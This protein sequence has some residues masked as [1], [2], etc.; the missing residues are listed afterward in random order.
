MLRFFKGWLANVAVN[1]IKKGPEWIP[2]KQNGK[3]VNS[4]IMVPVTFTLSD[5]VAIKNEPQ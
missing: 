5:N 3:A 4:Y 2:G 1:A